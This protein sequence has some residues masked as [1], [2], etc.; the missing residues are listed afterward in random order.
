MQ[1]GVLTLRGSNAAREVFI[2][3]PAQAASNATLQLANVAAGAWVLINVRADKQHEVRL[4]LN[5]D[6]LRAPAAHA[7]QFPRCR[8]A[9]SGRRPRLG[10]PAGSHGHWPAG[11]AVRSRGPLLYRTG[12]GGPRLA[13]RR[14]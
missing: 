1:G 13:T 14:L 4:R 5:Q 12:R 6:A 7:I 2:L 11:R 8:F 9:A 10:Q 3:T